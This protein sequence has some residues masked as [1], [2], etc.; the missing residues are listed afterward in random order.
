V[1]MDGNEPRHRP[2]GGVRPD[3]PCTSV[4]VS[5]NSSM[6]YILTPQC[7]IFESSPFSIGLLLC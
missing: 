7:I 1:V 5:F 4:S 6:Y 3:A 2:G